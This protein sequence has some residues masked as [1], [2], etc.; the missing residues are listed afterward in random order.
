MSTFL[1]ENKKPVVPY[2]GMIDFSN[3]ASY[4]CIHIGGFLYFSYYR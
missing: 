2:D 4:Q 1:I 3:F